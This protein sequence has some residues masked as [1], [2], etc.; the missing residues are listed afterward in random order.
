MYTER[1]PNMVDAYRLAWVYAIACGLAGLVGASFIYLDQLLKCCLGS[2]VDTD[3]E[4]S[5]SV[6]VVTLSFGAGV[7]LYTSFSNILPSAINYIKSAHQTEGLSNGVSSL[8]GIAGFAMGGFL[9]FAFNEI[10]HHYMPE[11]I[12]LCDTSAGE[13][14]ETG[15]SVQS[16]DLVRSNELQ[17]GE[18]SPLLK[19]KCSHSYF[20]Q[21]AI[22]GAGSCAGYSDPCCSCRTHSRDCSHISPSSTSDTGNHGLEADLLA[23]PHHHHVEQKNAM[24]R[25]AIQ[26]CVAMAHKLPEVCF[27]VGC[28][29]SDSN[30]FQGFI[31]FVATRSDPKLGGFVFT[32]LFIHNFTEGF[33]IALPLFLTLQSRSKAFFWSSLIGGFSQPLGALFGW[34]Y[35]Q[36]APQQDENDLA[37]GIIFAVCLLCVGILLTENR[38]SV[39]Y[40]FF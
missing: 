24:K 31:T 10:L 29:G 8:I 15:D 7:M 28:R 22:R 37:Y 14:L 20:D 6:L 17:T 4:K 23:A 21:D 40:W 27:A 11:N 30:V 35:L 33:I 5:K 36:G 32:S 38:A 34:L 19:R 3:F 39:E 25:L 16:S 9:F 1:K 26:M 13:D 2:K 18:T 12:I